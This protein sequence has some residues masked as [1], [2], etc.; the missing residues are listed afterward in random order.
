VVPDGFSVL[1]RPLIGLRRRTAATVAGGA[2]VLGGQSPD[3]DTLTR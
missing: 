2:A 3:G 1:A